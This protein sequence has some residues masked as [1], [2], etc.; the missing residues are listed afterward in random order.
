M[1]PA[2]RLLGSEGLTPVSSKLI[3]V[4]YLASIPGTVIL[5]VI[6]AALVVGG[7]WWE[8]W[9]MIA[10]AVLP[11]LIVLP[12]LIL[13]PRRVR[14]IGYRDREEDLVVASGLM[15]RSV[16]VTPYGRIQSVEI[17]EGPIER[18]F[19]L[20]T[21]S[22]TTASTTADGGIPGLERAEAERLRTLLSIRGIE[23][24]QSL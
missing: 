9:W 11:V 21:L 18:R 3:P 17:N 5:L 22:F 13:T 23:R 6:A 15:F 10:L 2:R 19:G 16:A 14:A 24:M 4:R 8:Q 20:C 1:T 12:G 7:L